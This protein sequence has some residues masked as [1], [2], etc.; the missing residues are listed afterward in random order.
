VGTDASALARADRGQFVSGSERPAQRAVV[1]LCLAALLLT[2]ALVLGPDARAGGSRAGAVE[3]V[4]RSNVALRAA[5]LQH[6]AVVVRRLPALHAVEVRPHGDAR[7]FAAALRREP[8]IATAR[9]VARRV[10]AV[11][12]ALTLGLVSTPAGGAYE[13]QYYA[14][15]ADRVPATVRAAARKITIAV[16]DTGADSSAPGLSN[17]IADAYDVRAGRRGAPD[18]NGH[19][20]F[21]ASLAAGSDGISGF[22]GDAR[23]LVVKVA[24]D[25]RFDDVD[26]AAG[27]LYA[28]RHGARIINLSVAGT[29]RSPVEESAIA[30]AAKRGVLLVAAAGNDAL[31]GNPAEY[32]AALLQPLGSNGIGGVGLAVGASDFTG[33]RAAFSEFG[34]FVSLAA[35]GASVF[36]AISS[37]S[38]A[39]VF[40]RSALPGVSAG[41]YGF[42]SGT[43]FAAPQV[44]GAAALV[45]A[46]APQLTARQVAAILKRTATGNGAWTPELG[47][48]VL[49]VSAAVDAAAQTV[50][51]R[52]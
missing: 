31:A 40:P 23:L 36:G 38:S 43:S 17:K 34:S 45:W 33:K 24:D 21:V 11:A 2:A 5:L 49:N 35:P 51:S 10:S 6:P 13:W 44:A 42:A 41:L 48:G 14:T 19:G 47:F 28:A 20:T 18:A 4:Y 16:L 27:I 46:A 25:T 39:G 32:P 22:G 7:A 26:V 8:G 3:I 37:R 1:G 50:L 9:L 12:P 29:T 52:G 30:F 15:S